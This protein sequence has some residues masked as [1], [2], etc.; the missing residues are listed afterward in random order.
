M[1]V[2][3]DDTS[4]NLSAYVCDYSWG[5]HK[6]YALY[7]VLNLECDMEHPNGHVV[8]S[9]DKEGSNKKKTKRSK[10]VK[11]KSIEGVFCKIQT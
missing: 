4:V 6:M 1:Y 10:L 2:H 11:E 9:E 5:I 3:S 8:R 7:I